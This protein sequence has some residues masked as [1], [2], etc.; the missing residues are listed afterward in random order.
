MLSAVVEG[1]GNVFDAPKLGDSMGI[2]GV[3]VVDCGDG[4]VLETSEGICVGL[5][6]MNAG[7]QVSS[8][9]KVWFKGDSLGCTIAPFARYHD[10]HGCD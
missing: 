2:E 5:K 10:R 7:K 3:G 8:L 6:Y 4:K 9:A 1:G